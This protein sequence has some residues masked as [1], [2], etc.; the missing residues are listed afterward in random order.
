MRSRCPAS[1]TAEFSTKVESDQPLVVDRTMSWDGADG[2]GAHAETAVAAPALTWYLAEGATDGG[3]DL[4]YLLQNPNATE[5]QVRVRYLRPS[6]APLEKTYTLPP[7]SR[8]NIWVNYEEFDGSGRALAGSD[9]SAVIDVTEQPRPSSSSGR[10]TS[11]CQG[12]LF[13]AGH[14]SAGVT[15]PA[16]QWFLAEGAT[17]PFFDL[18]VLVAN[19]GDTDAPRSRRPTCCRTAPCS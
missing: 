3:F 11:T 1:R 7:T 6:G 18:F 15:A 14:E 8:T 13:G 17:G 10:C 2:Y 5:A 16:T 4:F 9:V 12:R 19:P